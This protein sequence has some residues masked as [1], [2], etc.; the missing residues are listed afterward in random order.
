MSPENY[1]DEI[2]G[3]T[4]RVPGPVQLFSVTAADA[5]EP[6]RLRWN[7]S[8]ARIWSEIKWTVE[9][10]SGATDE[11]GRAEIGANPPGP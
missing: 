6:F 11:T 8:A 2:A 7:H 4:V 5:L 10:R 1:K 9:M 3:Q